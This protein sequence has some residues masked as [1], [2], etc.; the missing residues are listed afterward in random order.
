MTFASN[1]FDSNSFIEITGNSFAIVEIKKVG[2]A[3]R[4]KLATCSK[5][6]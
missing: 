1:R 3:Y 2:K 6:L 4:S 5:E